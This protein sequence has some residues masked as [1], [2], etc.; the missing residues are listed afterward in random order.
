MILSEYLKKLNVDSYADLND[1]E[2]RTYKEWEEALTGRKL[3][4]EDVQEFLA[5]EKTDAM[6]KLT[7]PSIELETKEDTFLK[8]KISLITAIQR[9]LQAP[10]MEKK[11]AETQIKR[12]LEN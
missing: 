11:M 9:F 2:K 3:T 12:L 1:E 10:E 4:D 5:I 8:M 6:I 7:H